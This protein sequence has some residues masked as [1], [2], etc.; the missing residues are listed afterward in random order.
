MPSTTS[1]STT[2]PSSRSTAYWA[3]EAPTLPAPT[4]VIFGR[5]LTTLSGSARPTGMCAPLQ[6]FHVLDD[7]GPELRALDFLRA[8]HEPREVVGHHLLPDGRLERGDDPVRRL[9]PAH[10][11]QHHLAGEDDRARIDLVLARV[12]GR[13][14]V[15]GLEEGVPALVVDVGAGGDADA[16]HLRGEGVGDEIARQVAARNDVE[17][18]RA[19]QDLLQEGVGDGVL[20]EGLARGRLAPAVVPADELVGE[21][22][23]GQGVAPLHEQTFRVLLD[24]A[25]VH[26]GHVAAPVLDGV[27]HGRADEALR[28][29]L[30]HRLDADGRALREADLRDLHLLLEELDD[31][32]RLGRPL[33]PLDPRVDVLG[34]LP[35]D[36]HVDLLGMLDGRG[37]AL[38]VAHGPEAHVEVEHLAQGHVERAETFADRR[39]Q[40]ALDGDQVLADDVEGLFGQKIGRAVLAVDRVRLL[41][42]V[43]LRPRELLLAPIGLLD[44]GVQHPDRG[45]P[46]V[47]TR[48]VA[49]DEGDDGTIRYLQLAVAD[50]DLLAYRDLHVGRH[51]IALLAL[52]VISR[53]SGRSPP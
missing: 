39:G 26:E 9:R 24:V 8:L 20:D 53:R 42:R 41:P 4:T 46:D 19:R 34:I 13:G 38:E 14:A 6:L 37:H 50:R 47:R 12:L 25:L 45:R 16:A 52:A 23:L 3:T 27:A 7:D 22:A 18:V 48:A 10:V 21:L 15:G 5:R 31:L 28:A 36:D 1:T 32:L 33:L 35:E 43:D 17:L 30:G 51:G 44:G 29:L 2:S 49:L 40:R 11:A